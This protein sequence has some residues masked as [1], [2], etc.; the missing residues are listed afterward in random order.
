MRAFVWLFTTLLS[1]L[2]VVPSHAAED[3]AKSSVDKSN[4]ATNAAVVK[5]IAPE[6][7]E[8]S[9]RAADEGLHYLREHQ[10][11]DGSWSNSVGITGL[12]VRAFLESHRGYNETD[13]PF[14]QKPIKFILS[15]VRENGAISESIQNENYNTAV[16]ITALQA[17]GNPDYQKVIKNGQD[18][19][20]KHQIDEGEEY[21]RDHRYYG[22]IGYG[23]DE[24]PDL[25]NQYLALEA[26][27]A[28]AVDPKD[29]VWEKALLF[30]NRSQ[31]RSESNDQSWAA[32]DGGFIYMPGNSP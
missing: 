29:P 23:G 4:A 22:G 26:L 2:I 7:S 25:S 30:V 32:N 17:T 21:T 12:A 10:A 3:K 9:K 13:G 15:Q 18:F 31:N 14:I 24:R 11:A 5:K 6:I 20:K 28:T 19:L 1:L 8:Q 16:A 27:K